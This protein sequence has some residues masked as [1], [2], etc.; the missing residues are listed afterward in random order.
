MDSRRILRAEILALNAL[1]LQIPGNGIRTGNTR[2]LLY[3]FLVGKFRICLVKGPLGILH[4]P[5]GFL[6]LMLHR[7]PDT[8]FSQSQSALRQLLALMSGLYTHIFLFDLVD[9]IMNFLLQSL[10]GHT[11]RVMAQFGI[12]RPVH[13]LIDRHG[14]R[15]AGSLVIDPLP[16][17][18][19]LLWDI[20]L[21]SVQS[22][23]RG[24][25]A[26]NGIRQRRIL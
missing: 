13:L 5:P 1:F 4:V 6:T 2:I 10:Q 22:V 18:F 7:L 21:G 25:G 9:F 19:A 8:V 20:L 23:R 12:G 26:V 15:P 14:F 17:L 16:Y 11:K 3:R 24:V